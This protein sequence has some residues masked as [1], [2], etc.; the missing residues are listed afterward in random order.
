MPAV[1]VW[2]GSIFK[3]LPQ[4]FLDTAKFSKHGLGTHDNVNGRQNLR[5]PG[6]RKLLFSETTTGS[7][8]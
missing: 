1:S 5:L 6:G 3:K 4:G 2:V 8:Y 7:T